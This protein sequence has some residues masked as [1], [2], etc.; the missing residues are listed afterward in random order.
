MVTIFNTLSLS[1]F[2]EIALAA[3]DHLKAPKHIPEM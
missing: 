2:Q 1:L 3:G